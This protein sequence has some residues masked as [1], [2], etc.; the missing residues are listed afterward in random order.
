MTEGGNRIDQEIPLGKDLKNA[1]LAVEDPSKMTIRQGGK[2]LWEAL[3]AIH[4]GRPYNQVRCGIT[5]LRPGILDTPI[6]GHIVQELIHKGT[7]RR[8]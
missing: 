6:G 2:V 8:G 4:E 3:A 1:C 5:S 7:N